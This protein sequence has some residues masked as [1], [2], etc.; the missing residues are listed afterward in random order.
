M[1]KCKIKNKV[2]SV[3]CSSEEAW[4]Y[5]QSRCMGVTFF[6]RK[7]EAKSRICDYFSPTTSQNKAISGLNYYSVEK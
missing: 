3:K 6:D 4:I 7:E 1:G 5:C 2:M